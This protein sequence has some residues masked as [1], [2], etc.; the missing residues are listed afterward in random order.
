[1]PSLSWEELARDL[2]LAHRWCDQIL[3][4]SLEGC[5]WQ[6]FL[7]RLR[8]FDWTGTAEPPPRAWAAALV[9]QSVRAGLWAS[10]HPWSMLAMTWVS[11]RLARRLRRLP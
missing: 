7:P 3:I 10:A 6:G 1:M 5:V 9:R 4:H 8:S 11:Y 2:R